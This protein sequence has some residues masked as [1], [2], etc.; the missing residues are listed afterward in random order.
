[1]RILFLHPSF[2]GQFRYLAPSLANK[3][4]NEVVFL[5]TRSAG[6]LSGVRKLCYD[7]PRPV[8]PQTH[9]YVQPLEKAVLQGQAA[10][11]AAQGLK[12]D[13]FI[14]DIIYGH[15]GS[16]VMLFM[17]DLFPKAELWGFFEWFYHAHGTDA[18]FDASEKL[19]VDDEARIRILN[20]SILLDLHQCNQ[21]VCPTL[22]QKSQFPKEY[23]SK[24]K[25]IP[26]QIDTT[27]FYPEP[28]AQMVLPTSK[29]NLSH[30]AEIVTYIAR[31]L[32]PYRG[33]LQF[34]E[35]LS[36]RQ[37]ES[38]HC[39]A[40]IVGEDHVFYGRSHPSGDTYK[41]I[42][43]KQFELD[44]SRVHFVGMPPMGEYRTI[45]QASSVHVHLCR[46]F[47]LSWSLLEAMACGCRIVASNTAPVLEVFSGYENGILT[48]F[49]SPQNISSCV[50]QLL[51]YES[52]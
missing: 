47:L 14:P 22:W 30:V 39:H 44:L 15:A 17:K 27:F 49:F 51:K 23:A 2:P 20:A 26:D 18:D 11:R 36:I 41:Q 3:P 21:G 13:G 9:R 1:M 29:L 6:Q 34:M 24:L 37:R 52:N 16:G 31:G 28:T 38:P 48:D 43:L 46:P 33:F 32:E 42:S 5:T 7:M 19:T 4:Q 8:H 25:V 35:A 50:D 40:V 10:Y 45:L 12:Q